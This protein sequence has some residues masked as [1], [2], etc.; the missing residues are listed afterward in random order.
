[1]LDEQEAQQWK[2]ERHSIE[3]GRTTGIRSRTALHLKM[4]ASE[5]KAFSANVALSSTTKI[6]PDDQEN[7]TRSGREIAGRLINPRELSVN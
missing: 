7:A 2:L 5:T 1:M 4:V 3:R 6:S